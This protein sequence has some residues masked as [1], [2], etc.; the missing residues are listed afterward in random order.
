MIF[1][2][3]LNENLLPKNSPIA[4]NQGQVSAYRFDYENEAGIISSA[5]IRNAAV[6]NAQIGT[7]AIGTANIGTLSFNEI[8]GGTATLGGTANGNGILRILTNTGGTV[9]TADNSGITIAGTSGTT[10]I[11]PTGLVSLNN[12]QTDRYAQFY[13]SGTSTT[14][15]TYVDVAGA[16]LG[17]FALNR[18]AIA[19]LFFNAQAH[20]N[21]WINDEN[22]QLRLSIFNGTTQ[23]LERI[24]H[25]NYIAAASGTTIVDEYAYVADLATLGAGT[26][27]AFRFSMR[28]DGG[29]TATLVNLVF[30]YIIF[31]R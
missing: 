24:F 22:H 28:A 18:S 16:T 17:T 19:Y 26:T 30:G 8:S 31:G 12:F 10:I 14:S 3:S 9:V 7:A 23:N 13:G 6:G 5:K 1:S 25:G 27:Q 2:D 21:D 15:T 20:N 11:D 4:I 29:G